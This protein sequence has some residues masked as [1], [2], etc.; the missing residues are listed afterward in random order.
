MAIKKHSSIVNGRAT[1]ISLE[2]EF[3]D[4]LKGIVATSREEPPLTVSM[5]LTRIATTTANNNLSSAVRVHI[6]SYYQERRG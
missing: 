1:S 4:A 3:W 5:L 2:P 6:L